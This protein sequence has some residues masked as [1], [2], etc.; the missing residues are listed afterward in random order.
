MEKVLT[1]PDLSPTDVISLGA[2]L[3]DRGAQKTDSGKHLIEKERRR[4]FYEL[5]WMHAGNITALETQ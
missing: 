1:C 4:K 3:K 2:D 5:G